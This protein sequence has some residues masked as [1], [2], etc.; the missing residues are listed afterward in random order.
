[1]LSFTCKE[2]NK[3]HDDRVEFYC[4]RCSRVHTF[5]YVSPF[6]CAVCGIEFPDIVKIRK[7]AS[8]RLDYHRSV[9][10]VH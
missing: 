9:N 3:H 4:P 6:R 8:Y 2:V 10:D 1:M 7:E 5:F